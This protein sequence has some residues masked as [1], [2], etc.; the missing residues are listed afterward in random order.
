MERSAGGSKRKSPIHSVSNE[1]IAMAVAVKNTPETVPQ[2]TA[3]VLAVGSLAGTVYVLGSLAI[4]FYGVP[5]LWDWVVAPLLSSVPFVSRALLL[6]VSAAVAGGLALVGARLLGPNPPRGIRAGI[7]AGT[8]GVVVAFL[9][10]VGIGHMLERSLGPGGA[11]AGP[12]LTGA[13]G[14]VLVGAWASLFFRPG[15]ERWLLTIEDQGWFSAAPYKRSQGQR[16]RRGTVLGILILTGCG[17]YTLIARDSLHSAA[18]ENW[19]VV[20]PFS[21]GQTVTLLPHLQF[22]L[23]ILLTALSLWLAYR[24][25]NFPPFADFLI[26]TEAEL[27]KVSWTTRRRLVQDTIVVLATMVLMTVFLFAV[28][29]IWV[30]LMSKIHVLQTSQSTSQKQDTAQDW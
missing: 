9:V 16:V 7:F 8:V 2:R 1:G 10:T 26:A 6:L 30:Q 20:L 28:D 5:T 29:V 3:N 27:N 14:V 23:P 18:S 4:L 19:S 25:V 22:T 17:V 12:W 11:A 24:I 15:F 21:N 13:I